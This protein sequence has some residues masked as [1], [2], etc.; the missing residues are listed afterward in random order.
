MKRGNR[1]LRVAWLLTVLTTIMLVIP[2]LGTA[3]S[4]LA[5][6]TFSWTLVGEG[7]WAAVLTL[8]WGAY[9]GANVAEKHSSF[10]QD[11]NANVAMG[12]EE[13]DPTEEFIYDDVE[14]D[15]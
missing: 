2:S 12:Y 4:G 5:G 3:L 6:W 8:V 11:Y 13:A 10:I 15:M 9:F 1:K 7:T 14:G